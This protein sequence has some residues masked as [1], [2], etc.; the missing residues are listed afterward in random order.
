MLKE[1]QSL[2]DEV[3][4]VVHPER[5][6]EMFEKGMA[7]TVLLSEHRLSEIR[8]PPRRGIQGPLRESTKH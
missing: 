7:R 5:F 4:A 1:L 3:S 2:Q 6:S 8:I